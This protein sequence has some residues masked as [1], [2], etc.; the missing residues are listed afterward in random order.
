MGLGV[1]VARMKFAK[2]VLQ[3]PKNRAIFRGQRRGLESALA[4]APHLWNHAY[5]SCCKR[6]YSNHGLAPPLSGCGNR[7]PGSQAGD[8]ADEAGGDRVFVSESVH[9]VCVQI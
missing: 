9:A 2:S 7:P 3:D 5:G 1:L 4:V 8:N 6:H